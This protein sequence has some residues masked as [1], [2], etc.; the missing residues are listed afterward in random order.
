MIADAS[1]LLTSWTNFYVI[2]GSSAGALIGL[3]F[4]VIALIA[5]SD[6]AGS[7]LEIRAFGT[8]TI[9]HFCFVLLIAGIVNVPWRALLGVAICL[10]ACGAFGV[11]Y[12]VVVIRHAYRQKGY[13]PDK[14]DWFWYVDA[15][16]VAYTTLLADSFWFRSHPA[17]ALFVVAGA[18]LALLFVGIHN[19]W[20][21]VTYVATKPRGRSRQE[22]EN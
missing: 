5:D 22:K 21:T 19:A 20:D 18:G 15:P 17:G 8:P 16:L 7:T 6:L 11:G 4:V 13:S 1:Q 3:Q 10:R 9:V 2:I 12:I 14:G